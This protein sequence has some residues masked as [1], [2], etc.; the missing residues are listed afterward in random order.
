MVRVLMV[1]LLC[2]LFVAK[3][4]SQTPEE[5]HKRQNPCL[6]NDK[7][8]EFNFWLGN[9]DVFVKDKKV[10]EN[11][12][13]TGSNGCVLVENWSNLAGG[14]GKSLNVYDGKEGVWKQFYVGSQGGVLLFSGG[15][16][17]NVMRLRG[18]TKGPKGEKI[19]NILEFHKLEDG[20][21]RQK[22]DQSSDGGKTWT[23]VWDS[24]YRKKA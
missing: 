20:S 19:D 13:E 10:G 8:K 17:G 6:Y 3:A 11:L 7:A 24:I 23:T 21:V 12:I 1:V 22:W 16:E 15:L 5:V 14:T 4:L 2:L 18:E 9:W